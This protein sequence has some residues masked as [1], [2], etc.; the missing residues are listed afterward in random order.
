MRLD[1]RVFSH[2]GTH[3]E[4]CCGRYLSSLKY[5]LLTDPAARALAVD[6]KEWSVIR[7]RL[8]VALRHRILYVQ[9]DVE[10]LTYAELDQL[11][12]QAFGAHISFAQVSTAHWS[13][14]CETMSV[15]LSARGRQT[16]RHPDGS[17]KSATALK[18]DRCFENVLGILERLVAANSSVLVSVENPRSPGFLSQPSLQRLAAQP[19]WRLIDRTDYCKNADCCADDADHDWPRKPTSLLLYGVE[20]SLQ[21]PVCDYDCQYRLL[22]DPR[23]HRA[24]LRGRSEHPAGQHVIRDPALR[25]RMPHGLFH[26]LWCSHLRLL[27]AHDRLPAAFRAVDCCPVCAVSAAQLDARQ[28]L[29]ELWH[30]RLGHPAPKRARATH[31][32]VRDG[33]L[34]SSGISCRAC[35]TGKICRRPHS[36]HLPRA[37]YPLGLVH[38]DLQGPFDVESSDGFNYSMLMTDDYTGRHFAYLLKS[39]G[40][41]GRALQIFI[42]QVGRPAH[43]RADNG[44]EFISEQVEGFMRMCRE[45]AIRLSFSLPDSYQQNGVAE[46]SHRTIVETTRT[47]LISARLPVT[48]WSW[49]YRHAVYLTTYLVGSRRPLSPYELW[50]GSTPSVRHLRCWGSRVTYK[51]PEAPGKLAPVGH[52][53]IFLGYVQ[54]AHDEKPQGI[55][56]CDQDSLEPKIVYTNDFSYEHFDES[57]IWDEP[58]GVSNGDYCVLRSEEWD[59]PEPPFFVA[60]DEEVRTPPPAGQPSLWSAYQEFASIRR[61]LLRKEGL[62]ARDIEARLSR[63]WH[64]HERATALKSLDDKR[65]TPCSHPLAAEV[66]VIKESASQSAGL[67]AS[68]PATTADAPDLGARCRTCHD[69]KCTSSGALEMILCDSCDYGNHRGCIDNL[70]KYAP[71][72]NDRW[73]CTDCRRAGTRIELWDRSSRQ[74]LPAVIERCYK[75]GLV[76]DIIY[77]DGNMEQVTL[78]HVRW[79]AMSPSADE[80]VQQLCNVMLD[81]QTPR[82]YQHALTLDASAAV[83][84]QGDTPWKAS[85]RKEWN[86]IQG[87]SVGI[88]VPAEKAI[89]KNLLACKW[90]YRIKW[91]GREK[92]RL[93]ALGCHQDV[94]GLNMQT[95]S[96]TPKM[97]TIRLLFAI[98]VQY[99][100]DIDL[101]D[102]ECAFLNSGLVDANGDPVEIY[103]EFP[104]GFERPGF[105]L[106]LQKSIYGLKSASS[107]W[108]HLLH[109]QLILQGFRRSSFD[110][111]LFSK[112]HPDGR[113]QFALPWVDDIL[114][115]GATDLLSP[116]KSQLAR[117]FTITGGGPATKYLGMTVERNR[118][119]GTLKLTNPELCEKIARTADVLQERRQQT[120]MSFARLSKQTHNLTPEAH[121]AAKGRHPYQQVVGMLQYL[122]VTCRPELSFSTKELGRYNSC[123]NTAAWLQARRVAT[124]TMQ[125]A[126]DGLIFRRDPSRSFSVEAFVDADYN[127][128]PEERLSTT[129]FFCIIAGMPISWASRTQKCCA[130]SVAEAEFVALATCTAEVLYLRQFLCELGLNGSAVPIRGAAHAHRVLAEVGRSATVQGIIRSDSTAAIANAKLP[131]GWLN[132]KLKH[133]QNAFFFFRQYYHAGWVD[134]HHIS[135]PLNPADGLTKGFDSLEEFLGK[136]RLLCIE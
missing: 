12:R 3:V 136:C 69:H 115:V 18:H 73:L 23:R 62:C 93:C 102:V 70:G 59:G 65:R 57:F 117:Y 7:D 53:S 94:D 24:V 129:G 51:P 126:Q 78:D 88:P 106:Q 130:R 113:T 71:G 19:G 37:D 54:G 111:C 66:P 10:D 44:G 64:E 21:L 85:M 60:C 8:P 33:P 128:T 39:K 74:Y 26:R 72:K 75:D 86:S 14:P 9:R 28:R 22:Q 25:S 20:D 124:Y 2:P 56:V 109:S 133:I 91:D 4:L 122:C 92:S 30:A 112:T 40:L 34:G 49:A 16:H 48:F 125:H 84:A 35:L 67:S 31:G 68:A 42:Q 107:D 116:T 41:A 32:H 43:I 13:P 1:C 134:F 80:V 17:A 82:N 127:G 87:A 89:G 120:P 97:S 76:A 38:T 108:G 98:A 58:V 121:A 27:R 81:A 36:G 110:S 104:R 105:V 132:D 100:L 55:I 119:A 15:S 61:P 101:C 47:L 45:N 29:S 11:C 96:A 63:E 6:I 103:M 123:F 52:R 99:D 5:H 135:G 50:F 114:M 79:R 90:V 131:V 118:A 95:A 46:R 83:N 77:E